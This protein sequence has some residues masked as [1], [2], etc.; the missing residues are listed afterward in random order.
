MR[1]SES[2][3]CGTGGEKMKCCQKGKKKNPSLR[4]RRKK[5]GVFA[6]LAKH[7]FPP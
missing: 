3:V 1:C 4:L 7:G 2:K 6:P 5:K